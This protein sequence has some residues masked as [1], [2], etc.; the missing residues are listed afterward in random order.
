ML[1]DQ[2]AI[3]RVNQSL[4]KKSDLIRLQIEMKL[5]AKEIEANT[6]RT[7]S[8]RGG[9]MWGRSHKYGCPQMGLQAD[10]NWLIMEPGCSYKF[11]DRK[12]T[13]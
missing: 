9:T 1:Q 7:D 3:R 10:R 12:L 5:V 6:I 8:T 2:D 4:L 11:D 13:L